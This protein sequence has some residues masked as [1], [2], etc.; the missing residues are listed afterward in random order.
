MRA[1]FADSEVGG[2]HREIRDDLLTVRQAGE[3]LRTGE[4]FV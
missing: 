1:Q 3:Y 2:A 4:R